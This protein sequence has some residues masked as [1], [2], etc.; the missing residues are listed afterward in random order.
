MPLSTLAPGSLLLLE[1][2]P[3]DVWGQMALDEWLLDLDEPSLCLRFHR[4]AGG[5]AASFGYSRPFAGIESSIPPHLR[6]NCTRRLTGGG[7][8]RHGSDVGFSCVFAYPTPTWNPLAVR[9]VLNEAIGRGF[10][11]LGL[12]VCLVATPLFPPSEHGTPPAP[13]FFRQAIDLELTALDD[14]RILHIAMRHRRNR[15]LCQAIVVMPDARGREREIHDAVRV[16]F[17]MAIHT[18]AATPLDWSP[19]ARFAALREKY[20]SPEWVYRL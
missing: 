15:V 13:S 4:W 20:H 7:L 2:P 5:P 16:G 10:Q 3:L 17:E 12:E 14:S 9:R 1:T 8:C 11:N 18:Q 6:A 19:D